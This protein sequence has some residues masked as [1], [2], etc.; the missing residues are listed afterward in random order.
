[1]IWG[2][3][4]MEKIIATRGSNTFLIIKSDER[5]YVLSL[6]TGTISEEMDVNAFLKFGYWEEYEGAETPKSL[7]EQLRCR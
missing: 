1:M 3:K 2:A 4:T 6:D 5:G 7:K